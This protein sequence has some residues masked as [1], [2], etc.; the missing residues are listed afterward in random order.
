MAERPGS[1]RKNIGPNAP[2]PVALIYHPFGGYLKYYAAHF[3][4]H[5]IPAGFFKIATYI[6]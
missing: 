5:P 1:Y 2:N 3:C 6:G 4:N